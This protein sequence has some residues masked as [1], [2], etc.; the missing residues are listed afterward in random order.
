MPPLIRCGLLLVSA[1]L[2]TG[3]PVDSVTVTL[4]DEPLRVMTIAPNF[5]SFSYEISGVLAMI[6][7][8][9][10]PPNPTFVRLMRNLQ[11]INGQAGPQLR[12][13]KSTDLWLMLLPYLEFMK[14]RS[15]AVGGN[16]AEFSVYWPSNASLPPHQSYAIKAADLQSYAA[17]LPLWNGTAVIDTSMYI[18]GNASWAIAHITAVGEHMGWGRIDAIEG[19]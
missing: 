7:T 17:A 9:P 10:N 16:S 6:G 14:L 3:A 19:A 2:V 8:Y 18:A 5:A 1:T 13:E 15:C 12:S 11:E 4:S